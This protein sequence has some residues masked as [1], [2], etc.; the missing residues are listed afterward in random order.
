MSIICPIKSFS[1]DFLYDSVTCLWIAIFT[2]F[3]IFTAKLLSIDTYKSVNSN[4]KRLIGSIIEFEFKTHCFKNF[5][6]LGPGN[7]AGNYG[8]KA[9][10]FNPLHIWILPLLSISVWNVF[11][12]F[13]FCLDWYTTVFFVSHRYLISSTWNSRSI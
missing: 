5:T 3:I 10:C 6:G 12:W 13:P 8:P 1:Y 2:R 4:S 11:K 9:F 7:F